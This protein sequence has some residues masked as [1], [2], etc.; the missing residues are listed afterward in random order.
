MRVGAIVQARMGS[1]R[2]PGKVLREA[3][4]RPLLS[5]LLERLERVRGLDAI[6]VAT[7]R[8]PADDP[9]AAFCCA[10]AVP[11][12][13]GSEHDVAGRFLLAVDEAGLEAFVRVN[14]DSPLLDGRLVERAL[15]LFRALAPDL[16]TNVH[17]RTYPP[18]ESVEVVAA[19]PFR[20]AYAEMDEAADLEH[21]TRFLYR[22]AERFR[23]ENFTARRSYGDLSLAVDTPEDLAR[24]DALLARLERPHW[25]YGVDELAELA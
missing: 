15:E 23:I 10:Q 9:V 3:A 6:V 21:V 25:S 18:G 16:V 5:Y 1:A 20:R 19:A 13:R 11:C 12:V 2:L 8:E 7:S 22:H 14:G 17:P 24:V 4:G